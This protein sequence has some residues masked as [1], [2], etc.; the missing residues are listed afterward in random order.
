MSFS[1]DFEKKE[2]KKP[3][4]H[5]QLLCSHVLFGSLF[6]ALPRPLFSCV[7]NTPLA[8]DPFLLFRLGWRST[9]SAVV[10]SLHVQVE[11]SAFYFV[12]MGKKRE[13]VH[14][15]DSLLA[16]LRTDSG[17]L[18]RKLEIQDSSQRPLQLACYPMSVD[19]QK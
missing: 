9:V 18:R 6:P 4:I 1:S 2:K 3:L 11:A 13:T 7:S 12:L 16:G 10:T 15:W 19:Q 5:P 17:D 8:D 14:F